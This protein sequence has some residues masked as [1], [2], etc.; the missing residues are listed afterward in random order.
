[1][2]LTQIIMK[3][4][5]IKIMIKKNVKKDVKLIIKNLKII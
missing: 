2:N 4:Q 3:N 5:L 1:M